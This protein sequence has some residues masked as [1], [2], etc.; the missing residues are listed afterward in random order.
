MFASHDNGKV[1]I[2]TEVV[3]LCNCS[4]LYY[5]DEETLT[6]SL[7]RGRFIE[8]HGFDAT[9]KAQK[10]FRHFLG[11]QFTKHAEGVTIGFRR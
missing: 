8:L 5:E 1:V 11:T 6:K 2:Y 9:I 3:V 4:D 10:K 7:R